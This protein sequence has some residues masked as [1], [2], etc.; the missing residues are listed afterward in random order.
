MQA[1]VQL[2]LMKLCRDH[3]KICLIHQLLSCTIVKSARRWIA[4]IYHKQHICIPSRCNSQGVCVC[5]TRSVV[6]MTLLCLP[7]QNMTSTFDKA[8]LLS[9]VFKGTLPLQL[10]LIYLEPDINQDVSVTLNITSVFG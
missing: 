5:V 8:I 7:H 10:V 1:V 4:T 9:H 3:Y 2:F 6:Q